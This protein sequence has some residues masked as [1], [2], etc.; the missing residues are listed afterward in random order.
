MNQ[1]SVYYSLP[2]LN[3]LPFAPLV[4][5]LKKNILKFPRIETTRIKATLCL[6]VT[7]L[8]L[9]NCEYHLQKQVPVFCVEQMIQKKKLLLGVFQGKNF[10]KLC[11]PLRSC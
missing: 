11:F 3:V 5:H 2:T 8:F 6:T 9:R 7:P 4:S 10:L 1:A